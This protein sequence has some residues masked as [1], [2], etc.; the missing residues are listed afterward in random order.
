ME[1][2]LKI[3][4]II[5]D[6]EMQARTILKRLLDSYCPEIEVIGEGNSIESGIEVITK[7]TT[8][9]CFFG[10]SFRYSK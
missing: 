8:R 4:T 5:I 7:I 6:N 3:K 1:T 10:C 2:T 9:P